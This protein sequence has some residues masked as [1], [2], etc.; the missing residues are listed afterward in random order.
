MIRIIMGL[1]IVLCFSNCTSTD[2]EYGLDY[3]EGNWR[4][5]WST[6]MRSDSMEIHVEHDSAMI[7]F[8]PFTSDFTVGNIKWFTIISSSEDNIDFILKDVS[9]D[10]TVSTATFKVQT[11]STFDLENTKFPYAP[12]SEQ[13]WLRIP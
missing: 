11:D 13:K 10:N 4:R 9:P 7:T 2:P 6:D 1:M 3:L 5:T 12:G 8:V